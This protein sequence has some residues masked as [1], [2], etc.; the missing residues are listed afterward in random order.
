MSFLGIVAALPDEAVSLTQQRPRPAARV[1]LS[2]RVCVQLSGIG[3]QRACAAANALLDDGAGAL[4]SWG[5]AAGLDPALPVGCLVLAREIISAQGHRYAVDALWHERLCG[6]LGTEVY[7][8][9]AAI[10]ETCSILNGP[11]QKRALYE[12]TG[13]AVADMES[14]AVAQV[15]EQGRVPMLA[16][17]AVADT[18]RMSLPGCASAA[19]SESGELVLREFFSRLLRHPGEAL[20]VVGT[21]RAMLG[22]RAALAKVV[23]RA[24]PTVAY[25]C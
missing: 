23:R 2:D 15:A 19:M 12:R 17:R 11:H 16:V 3:P 18:A 13:A 7:F 8:E 9:I 4:L 5:I 20:A 1:V 24:G 25:D 14:A 6:R 10:A 22:A 21:G